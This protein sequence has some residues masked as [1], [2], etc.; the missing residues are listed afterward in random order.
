MIK[1]TQVKI[2]GNS[3]NIKYYTEKGYKI[4]VGEEIYID[5]NDLSHGSTFKIDA[6]CDICLVEK[7]VTWSSYRKIINSDPDG[8]YY[9]LSCCKIKRINTNQK[10]YGGNSPTKSKGVVDKIKKTN[11]EKYGNSSSLHGS[12]QGKI[13]NILLDKYGYKSVLSNP[14]YRRIIKNTIME[15]YGVDHPLKNKEIIEKVIK[16]N[17]EKWGVDNVSKSDFV[18]QKIKETNFKKYGDYYVKTD[19]FKEKSKL[20]CI[21]KYGHDFY[22]K[23]GD[24]LDRVVKNKSLNYPNLN[25]IGYDNSFFE[26]YCDVCCKNYKI[27]TD[28]LYRRSK[29]DKVICTNCNEVGI[30]FSSSYED[31][32]CEFLSL[33]KILYK[34][35]INSVIYPYHID[36][37]IEDK[38]IGIEFNGIYWHNEYNKEKM[39]HIKKYK[40]CESKSIQLI[41]IWEDDWNNKKEIIKSII[42]NKIG[43]IKSKIHARKCE[44]KL[45][46]Y[47]DKKI[48]LNNNH[49][50]GNCKSSIN[51]GLIFN[52]EIVS[53]MTFGKRNING[54]VE[55]ELIRF[56]NLKNTIII[57]GAS[58]LFKNFIKRFE[59]DKIVSYSDNC[60]SNGHIYTKLGF[61]NTNESIN[62]Y[63]CD[64][65]DKY[66]RFVFN[67]KRLVKMGFD[68][69]KTEVEIMHENG[70]YRI[71]GA[72]NKRWDY[73][74]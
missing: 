15:K 29:H 65:K 68:P 73:K 54:N 33:N 40:M 18:I 61:Q 14:E 34:R 17:I 26:I 74:R 28:L 11:I 47:K 51:I 56:C 48:F 71:W 32:I 41:Q 70:Y 7:K 52:G 3:R 50:Q 72:G 39:Y 38:K 63:W 64:G 55:Y 1:Q 45:I 2:I 36:I 43:L 13:E 31:E 27:R 58:K 60:I 35:N 42:L 44:V 24:Y 8:K 5:I 10:K 59:F 23:S 25:I 69:L 53:I 30:K 49:I 12:N 9:C 21:S 67:K 22:N 37:Y 20:S 16:T 46:N 62:Y 19:D 66:H 4:S 57:G 6:L